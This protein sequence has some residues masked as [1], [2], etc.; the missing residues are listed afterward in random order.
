[1]N[2]NKPKRGEKYSDYQRNF[3]SLSFTVPPELEEEMNARALDLGLNRSQ[4]ICQ[5]VADDINRNRRKQSDEKQVVT[6]R[7]LA[8]SRFRRE[9]KSGGEAT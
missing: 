6:R 7:S 5:I 2:K 8:A 3:V 4:Y 1:M 9:K